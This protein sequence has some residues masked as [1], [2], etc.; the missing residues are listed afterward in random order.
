MDEGVLSLMQMAKTSAALH[1]HDEA[2]LVCICVLTH[3][4]LAGVSASYAFLG[5]FPDR[6]TEGNDR[7]HR[8][9]RDRTDD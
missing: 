4:T 8:C 7:L 9:A 3:P 5:D 2:G 1:R 6:R